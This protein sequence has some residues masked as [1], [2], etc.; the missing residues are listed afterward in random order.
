MSS[1]FLNNLFPLGSI[2]GLK[3]ST[4]PYSF[5]G[6]FPSC[7]HWGGRG[8]IR[9]FLTRYVQLFL[10]QLNQ[11][12]LLVYVRSCER[13]FSERGVKYIL[14]FRIFYSSNLCTFRLPSSDTNTEPYTDILKGLSSTI[15]HWLA[16]LGGGWVGDR[17]LKPTERFVSFTLQTFI[18]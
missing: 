1:C 7:S 8:S 3:S 16:L 4:F 5:R 10:P 17:V 9:I 12:Y 15:S 18:K 6:T 11:Q 14:N 2:Q 13:L